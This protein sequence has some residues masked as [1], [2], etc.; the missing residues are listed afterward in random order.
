MKSEA[1]DLMTTLLKLDYFLKRCN[2]IGLDLLVSVVGI[3]Y[4]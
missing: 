2:F 4:I 3:D 1:I